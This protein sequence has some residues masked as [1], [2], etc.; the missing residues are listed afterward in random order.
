[1]SFNCKLASSKTRETS[2]SKLSECVK[3]LS[4]FISFITLSSSKI[5]I[6]H[7]E[8]DVVI[9]NTFIFKPFLNYVF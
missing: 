9:L 1:M 6:P 8:D 5:A 2:G 7:I 4:K 3:P